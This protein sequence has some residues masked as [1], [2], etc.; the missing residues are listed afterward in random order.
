MPNLI[1]PKSA[2]IT[3]RKI[4]IKNIKIFSIPEIHK[5]FSNKNLG[6]FIN[7]SW[8]LKFSHTA[9]KY[10]KISLSLSLPAVRGATMSR[11]GFNLS[12]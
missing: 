10:I 11:G 2:P 4:T 5:Y 6:S 7:S 8:I 12:N 3:Q 1:K 9:F